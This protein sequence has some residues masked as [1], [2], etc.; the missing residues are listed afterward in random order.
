MLGFIW[1]GA[2]TFSPEAQQS[3]LAALLARRPS[4]LLVAPT[5]PAA[6]TGTLA[7][8]RYIDRDIPVRVVTRRQGHSAF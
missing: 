4:A 8:M 6:L 5:D 2:A 3:V 1:Q 7:R